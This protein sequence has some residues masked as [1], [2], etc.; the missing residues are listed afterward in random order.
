MKKSNNDG[1][2][3]ELLGL[4]DWTEPIL[5]NQYANIKTLECNL[6]EKAKEI[7]I[8]PELEKLRNGFGEGVKTKK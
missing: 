1:Y 2:C 3:E 6:M 4:F 5:S 8:G 7:K